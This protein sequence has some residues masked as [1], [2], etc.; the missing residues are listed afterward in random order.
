MMANDHPEQSGS[1]V[2]QVIQQ[3]RRGYDANFKLMV[4]K[5][6]ETSKN[7][8]AAKKYS[9]SDFNVR[10]WRAHFKKC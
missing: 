10:R 6:A 3:L 1:K 4:I 2:G 7:S 9:V 5:A 8:Q